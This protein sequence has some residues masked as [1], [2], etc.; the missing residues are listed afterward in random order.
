MGEG[1][2][3]WLQRDC[4]QESGQLPTVLCNVPSTQAL[5]QPSGTAGGRCPRLLMGVRRSWRPECQPGRTLPHWPVFLPTCWSR[6]PTVA[7]STCSSLQASPPHRD[8]DRASVW[9]HLSFCRTRQTAQSR[10]L[11][12]WPQ[13]SWIQSRL[14]SRQPAK[15]S[16]HFS[17]L[18]LSFHT[19]EIGVTVLPT[20][21]WMSELMLAERCACMC[22]CGRSE[23]K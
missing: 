8:S 14:I 19:C 23:V 21:W 13:T 2:P 4:T 15:N 1:A 18:C 5:C 10:E 7:A 17:P 12:L 22:K 11:S 9:H 16:E 3:C 6:G 20:S